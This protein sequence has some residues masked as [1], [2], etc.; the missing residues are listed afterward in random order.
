MNRYLPLVLCGVLLNASAQLFLK[1]GMRAIG[2]FSFVAKNFISVGLK[3]ALNPHILLGM[4]CYAFSIIVWLMVL[5]R[6]DVSYAYPLP[7]R[8]VYRDCISRTI[9]FGEVL[10]FA[11]WMGILVI[12]VGVILIT[13]SG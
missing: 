13:R 8:R 1:Q 10:G 6:V 5:S 4:A 7:K 2:P 12:C 9:F 3:V 11:R